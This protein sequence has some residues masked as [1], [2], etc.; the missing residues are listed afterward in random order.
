MQGR[1]GDTVVENGLVDTVREGK[2]G[3]NGESSINTHTLSCVKRIADEKLLYNKGSPIWCSV[4]A[5]R[6]GW[7]EGM[8]AQEGGEICIIMADGMLLDGRNP[9][10]IVKIKKQKMHVKY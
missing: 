2:S 9:Q 3:M 10:N 5:K 7:R 8:E 6:V 4:M 1:T